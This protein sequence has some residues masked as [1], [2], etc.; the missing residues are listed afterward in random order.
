MSTRLPSS[1]STP[2]S[3]YRTSEVTSRIIKGRPSFPD[4]PTRSVGKH[5]LRDSFPSALRGEEFG[6]VFRP[7]ARS[8]VL[9]TRC[10]GRVRAWR[11]IVYWLFSLRSVGA[12]AT[13]IL[14]GVCSRTQ[15]CA[16]T[17][18]GATPVA[19][20]LTEKTRWLRMRDFSSIRPFLRGLSHLG[21]GASSLW[22]GRPRARTRD[23]V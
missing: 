19:V 15:G 13:L 9:C 14:E 4:Q 21:D 20:E 23:S 2:D 7:L 17:I 6:L 5:T 12:N 11:S 16:W 1:G 3:R 22:A 8:F 18:H 10:R